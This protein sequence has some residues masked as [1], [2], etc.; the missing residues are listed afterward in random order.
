MVAW[1]IYAKR[2]ALGGPRYWIVLLAAFAVY[3]TWLRI[4]TGEFHWTVN[5]SFYKSSLL[6]YY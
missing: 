5:L 3:T 4:S 6:H 1:S 2:L